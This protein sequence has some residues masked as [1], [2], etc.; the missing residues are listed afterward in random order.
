[1]VCI[2]L[3]ILALC[4]TRR[5]LIRLRFAEH[6]PEQF[7]CRQFNSWCGLHKIDHLTIFKNI[8][9]TGVPDGPKNFIT[10]CLGNI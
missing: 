8:V 3:P 1:M 4:Q 2:K 5:M 9:G 7:S 10:D 6:Q